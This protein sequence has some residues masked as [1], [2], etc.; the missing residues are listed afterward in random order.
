MRYDA[1]I[2]GSGFGGACAGLTLA[3]AGARV[4]L[5][6]RGTPVHR[7]ADD[8]NQRRILLERRYRMDTPMLVRQY[9]ARSYLPDHPNAVVGGSSVFYG[10]ASLR[11]REIDFGGWPLSYGDL[12]PFYG[13]AEAL[14]GVHG[15]AGGDPR[16]PPRSSDYPHRPID[17]TAP[18]QRIDRAARS[19]GY[20][21]F[22][23]PLAI[24]FRDEGRPQCIR[25][26]TCDGFPC[27][28]RAKNDVEV[29]VLARS[30][31]AGLEV[32]AGVRAARLRLAGDR[33]AAVECVE[34]PGG[35]T[36][37]VEADAFV[38]AAGALHTPAILLRSGIEGRPG[39]G[40]V[41]RHLMRHCN[42][43]LAGVFPFRTNPEQ[44]FH[45]QI[46][47]TDFYED[48]RQDHG[49]ATGVIQDIYTPDAEVIR[50]HAP[51]GLG[52]P[53]GWAAGFMQNLLCIAEDESRAANAVALSA[54]R[55][56]YGLEILT[57]DHAYTDAD[58]QRLRYL[59]ARARR[60]LRRAGALITHLYAIDTFSHAMGTAR[61]ATR[62]DEG[63]VD[64]WGRFWG[65]ENV[66]VTDGSVFPRS[67]GV[68]PSLTIA[69]FALRASQALAHP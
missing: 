12:E 10:G 48:L 14:L 58:R 44:V 65:L 29:T 52:R 63:A 37:T 69:A 32:M 57:V 11:L 33:A 2:V 66:H 46:C 31:E 50:H 35:R 5:L 24:N 23:M 6:E 27:Q 42:G 62:P 7:D 49:T 19:L 60:V 53:A 8:W 15:R 38:L 67:G 61:A 21:P 45:K 59:V 26:I 9:G 34:V 68:N 28:I 55:D 16:E 13:Q 47:L 40:F 43:V 18:A 41:G 4:L 36:F 30:Q 25:C 54:Q 22:A 1:V 56:G 39:A 20:R 51:R 64:A 3:R 17:L